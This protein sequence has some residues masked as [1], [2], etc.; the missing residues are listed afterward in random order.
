[1]NYVPYNQPFADGETIENAFTASLLPRFIAESKS[2]AGGRENMF[3]FTGIELQ[4]GTSM[5]ISIIGEAYANYGRTGGMVFMLF[6]GLVFSFILRFIL[7]KSQENS[8]LLLWIPFLFLQVI[9]AETD[10]ITTLNYVV[11]ASIAMFIVFWS[12]RYILKVEI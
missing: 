2:T 5:N 6:I 11:K 4:Q 8:T 7:L 10:L 12:F 9:K 3:R 1:M